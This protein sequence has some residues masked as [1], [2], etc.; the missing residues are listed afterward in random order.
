[1]IQ[2]LAASRLVAEFDPVVD[3]IYYDPARVTA[4][5][6][7]IRSAPAREEVILASPKGRWDFL[8]AARRHLAPLV[9]REELVVAFGTKGGRSHASRSHLTS[10]WR[11]VGAERSVLL[12]PELLARL[13]DIVASDE[14]K[15]FSSTT[16]HTSGFGELP[17][18]WAFGSQR[19]PI[20]TV[21][22][23]YRITERR[24]RRGCNKATPAASA[25]I[26]LTKLTFASSVYPR[27]LAFRKCWSGSILR[28]LSRAP[29]VNE[30]GIGCRASSLMQLCREH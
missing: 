12:A 20:Q 30:R 27:G 2:H 10:V 13:D 1:M 28:T 16:T 15:R 9:E 11:D 6:R 8:E 19:P 24:L 26:W 7:R 17:Q 25:G 3:N 21:M 29:D 4:V 14:V 23:P 18:N 5:L 22:S